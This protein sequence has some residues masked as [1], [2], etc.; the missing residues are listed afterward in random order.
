MC[1]LS[2]FFFFFWQ[3]SS[4][5]RL[6]SGSSG[7]L[8]WEQGRKMNRGVFFSAFPNYHMLFIQNLST[9]L[10]LSLLGS[11]RIAPFGKLA[12]KKQHFKPSAWFLSTPLLPPTYALHSPPDQN[13]RLQ[14]NP[15][16]AGREGD[17]PKC[18]P[19]AAKMMIFRQAL[20]NLILPPWPGGQ[21]L[22]VIADCVPQPRQQCPLNVV[23]VCIHPSSTYFWAFCESCQASLLPILLEQLISP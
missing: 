2:L 13:T 14:R 16:P 10:R 20:C 8:S 18:L 5:E 7:T 4:I 6:Q 15:H 11:I 9:L 21:G 22:T 23:D 17:T 3:S 12:I 19:S 1:F